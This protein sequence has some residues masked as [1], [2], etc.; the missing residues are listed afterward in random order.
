MNEIQQQYKRDTGLSGKIG[1]ECTRY[2]NYVLNVEISI[3][4][5][6]D[7]SDG[8]IEFNTPEYVKWLEEKLLE[9]RSS[10]LKAN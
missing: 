6:F 10:E 7:D 1:F 5:T 3:T 4:D 8:I 9:A 2:K